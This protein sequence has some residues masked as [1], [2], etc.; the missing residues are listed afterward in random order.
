MLTTSIDLGLHIHPQEW[1]EQNLLSST[2]TTQERK[3]ADSDGDSEEDDSDDPD[4]DGV[5]RNEKGGVIIKLMQYTG[6][7]NIRLRGKQL[8][9]LKQ[10]I[11]SIME[12]FIHQ[13]C[14][15]S[16]S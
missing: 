12:E 7:Q 9:Q 2:L 16:K 14:I 5:F 10:L 3:K 8:L 11:R 13:L 6:E 1:L 15:L 4:M